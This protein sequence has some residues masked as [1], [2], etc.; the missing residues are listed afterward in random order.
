MTPRSLNQFSLNIS[1]LSGPQSQFILYDPF[2]FSGSASDDMGISDRQGLYVDD[3]YKVFAF[4]KMW[5][6]FPI[7]NIYD[8]EKHNIVNKYETLSHK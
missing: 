4:P 2:T 6:F 1:Q 3:V 5:V 7:F 8:N